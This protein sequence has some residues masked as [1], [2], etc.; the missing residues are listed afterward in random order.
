MESML[1][2]SKEYLSKLVHTMAHDIKGSLHNI[3]GYAELLKDEHNPMF[4]EKIIQIAMKQSE[5]VTHSV[6]L[7]D[8]GLFVDAIES[9]NLDE[10]VRSAAKESLPREVDY[11]QDTLP[12]VIGDAHRV[13]QIFTNLFHIAIDDEKTTRIEVRV[14]ETPRGIEILVCSDGKKIL[15]EESGL[16][17]AECIIN[18][19]GWS[20]EVSED[21]NCLCIT[22]PE[23]E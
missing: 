23:N 7:V 19:H 12:E 1:K 10:L 21:M 8:V 4:V 20:I 15:L 14:G 13:R 16:A 5:M 2:T 3:M 17:V 11:H 6:E 22:I 18:A 9:I